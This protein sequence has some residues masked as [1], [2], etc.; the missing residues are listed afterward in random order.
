M[1]SRQ[2]TEPNTGPSQRATRPTLAKEKRATWPPGHW[3]TGSTGVLREFIHPGVHSCPTPNL[4][5]DQI[6][7]IGHAITAVELATPLA[8]SRVTIFKQMAAGRIPSFRV[9]TCVRFDHRAVATWLR[10]V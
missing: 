10:K 9:G 4:C 5:P 2:G 8:V 7:R 6:E 3:G 1:L